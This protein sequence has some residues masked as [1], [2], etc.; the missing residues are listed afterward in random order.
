MSSMS[1]R[2]PD[3]MTGM[4]SA[5]RQLDRGLDVDAGEHAVAANVRVDHTF[6]AVVFELQ[7]QVHHLV[8]GELAPAIGGNLGPPWRPGPR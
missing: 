7:G 2:P 1:D 6:D 4:D 5:L 3:A 8:A